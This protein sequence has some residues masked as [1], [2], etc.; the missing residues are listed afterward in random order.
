LNRI[1]NQYQ[2]LMRQTRDKKSL[3]EEIQ[4]QLRHLK[5]IKDSIPQVENI[6]SLRGLEGNCASAYFS[7]LQQIV[8]Q[9]CSEPF[10]FQKRTRRPPKDRFNAILS[11][12]Y[13][14]LYRSVYSSILIV[15][16]EPALGYYH[17]PRSSAHPLVLDVMELFRIPIWDVSVL[18]S[19][20]RNLWHPDDDFAITPGQVWLSDNGRKKAVEFFENR[21]NETWKHPVLDYSLS[22][23]RHIELEVRLLEKTW[24]EGK[25]LYAVS[26]LR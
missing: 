17:T 18:S 23:S 1:E 4:N 24:T 26:A 9:Y 10:Q 14:L 15:G 25:S 12:G 11:Y 2:L 8:K 16:L 5:R 20:R 22:Y 6:A 13:S 7:A 3:R 19:L 21:L